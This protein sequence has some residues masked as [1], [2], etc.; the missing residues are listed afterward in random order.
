MASS[1]RSNA[2]WSFTLGPRAITAWRI[3]GIDLEHRGA[4]ARCV[5]RHVAPAD[6]HLALDPDEVLEPL[7]RRRA[8]RLVARQEAH[9]HRIIAGRRQVEPLALRPG[10]EQGVG[11]LDQAAGAVADLGIGADAAA[12]V[13]VGEDLRGPGR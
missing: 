2:S 5:D 1:L 3:T 10:A 13:E 8:A 7:D 6:Q 12:M 11:D 9:R 4:D